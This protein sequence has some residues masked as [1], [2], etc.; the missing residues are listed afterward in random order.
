[1]FDALSVSKKS[2]NVIAW[3]ESSHYEAVMNFLNISNRLRDTK[4]IFDF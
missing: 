2:G 4:I 3:I 1:M